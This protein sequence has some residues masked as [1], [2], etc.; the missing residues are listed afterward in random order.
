MT[1]VY[2][3]SVE[4][5]SGTSNVDVMFSSTNGL[6]LCLSINVK[7]SMNFTLLNL[8][9]TG[10]VFEH[11]LTFSLEVDVQNTFGAFC[12][13]IVRDAIGDLFHYSTLKKH[14]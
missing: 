12:L 9:S 11:V 7:H 1:S 8:E 2:S 4:S 10:N 5:F 14:C 13:D 6:V 3:S